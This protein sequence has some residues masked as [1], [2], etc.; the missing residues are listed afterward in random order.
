MFEDILYSGGVNTSSIVMA[1]KIAT[2]GQE[3][4]RVCRCAFVGLSLQQGTCITI[5]TQCQCMTRCLQSVSR[6]AVHTHTLSLSLSLSLSLQV[7]GVAFCDTTSN[8]IRV[9]EF[10]D[11]D[12][13][14]NLEVCQLNQ[15]HML[16]CCV[17]L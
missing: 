10:V 8:E 16:Q 7:V 1:V 9:C 12:Q 14:S 3:K 4:V 13:F 2:E 11:N 15:Q 6:L 5:A 17:A